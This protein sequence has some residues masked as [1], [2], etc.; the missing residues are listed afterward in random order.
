MCRV[1]VGQL[2]FHD[3][4]PDC[5][6]FLSLSGIPHFVFQLWL[7]LCRFS[8][9]PLPLPANSGFGSR[10]SSLKETLATSPPRSYRIRR[11]S[12]IEG[13]TEDEQDRMAHIL[14]S[15]TL[16]SRGDFSSQ[17]NPYYCSIILNPSCCHYVYVAF[18]FTITFKNSVA[19]IGRC[20]PKWL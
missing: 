11:I 17:D 2:L 16:A 19:L 9:I 13:L 8:T 15:N 12:S 20:F 5:P 7:Q 6:F 4:Q 18:N 14:V 1:S 3:F 10:R